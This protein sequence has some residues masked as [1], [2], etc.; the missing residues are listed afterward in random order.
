METAFLH[1]LEQPPKDKVEEM[2]FLL[3]LLQKPET[4]ALIKA[5]AASM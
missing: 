1:I 5:L 2:A 4:A 3:K